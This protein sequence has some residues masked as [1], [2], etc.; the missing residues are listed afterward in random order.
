MKIKAFVI[1]VEVK[2]H[3]PYAKLQAA[4]KN[5]KAYNRQAFKRGDF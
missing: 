3:N 5:K 2:K 1:K 4:H